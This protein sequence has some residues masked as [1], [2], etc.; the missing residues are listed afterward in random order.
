MN[1]LLRL[2]TAIL[3]LYGAAGAAGLDAGAI[4][5]FDSYAPGSSGPGYGFV[6]SVSAGRL[7]F[8]LYSLLL[9]REDTDA[10]IGSYIDLSSREHWSA[11][12][13]F[14]YSLT[15]GASGF[16]L[17]FRSRASRMKS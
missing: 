2:F 13:S 15:P 8:G 5:G 1:Y 7:G 6:G 12:A 14:T 16:S 11:G 4:V 9:P 3:A 10:G 17:G